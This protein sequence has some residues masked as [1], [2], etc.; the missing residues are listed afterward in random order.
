VRIRLVVVLATL[1]ALTAPAR[2]FDTLKY[3]GN[4]TTWPSWP[5]KY[6]LD[7]AGSSDVA[8]AQ[9]Q[10]AIQAA[11]Q[12][13][14]DVDCCQL[15]FSYGGTKGYSNSWTGVWVHFTKSNWDPSVGDA[16][17]YSLSWKDWNGNITQSEINF[18]DENLSWTTTGATDFF[19][20]FSDIQGVATHEIGHTLG[21]DHSKIREA[22]MFFSGGSQEL[23]TLKQDDRNGACFLYPTSSFTQGQV[24]DACS[25]SANCAAGECVQYAQGGYNY[26]GK[27]CSSDSQCPDGYFCYT[28]DGLNTCIADT[29]Y[30]NQGGNNVGTG[31]YCWGMEV[32]QSSVCL[33][34]P[35]TAYC[36]QECN[37]SSSSGC[38][39]GYT[40][41][42]S[43]TQGYCIKQ[44]ATAIGGT[45]SMDLEC[46]SGRCVVLCVGKSYCSQECGAGKPACPGGSTCSQGFCM[47]T[48]SLALGAACSCSVDCQSGYC[49][50]AEGAKKCLKPCTSDAEC[51]GSFCDGGVCA[52]G[53][54]CK[55]DASCGAGKFC[56]FD[57]PTQ[58]AGTCEVACNPMFDSGCPA[59]QVCQW[60]YMGWLDALRGRCVAANGGGGKGA[61]CDPSSAP[62]ENH[63]ICAN[64]GQG[65]QCYVDCR[66]DDGAG[67]NG[68]EQCVG[69]GIGMDP[70]HGLCV[71][72]PPGVEPHEVVQPPEVTPQ[73]DTA[74][75]PEG[76]GPTVVGKGQPCMPPATVC[77]AGLTCAEAG[78]GLRCYTDCNTVTGGCAADEQC[79]GWNDPANR[80]VC[81]PRPPQSEGQGEVSQPIEVYVPPQETSGGEDPG[82]DRGGA[83]GGFGCSTGGAGGPRGG[84]LSLL[85]LALLA[86]GARRRPA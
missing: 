83:G 77:T 21:L 10:S 79:V 71:P 60:V 8:F 44:G 47:V 38:P 68:D 36:S 54:G 45:C 63:L 61:G 85:A 35:G 76:S 56:R 37:P 41:M 32:C 1:C 22:V 24:C 50:G 23:R 64:A 39:A 78:Q 6:Y 86:L 65:Q 34:L 15:T 73:Q 28:Q 14:Q 17:A 29:Y 70:K 13:W 67:C 25:S 52:S 53:G 55:D 74:W 20:P 31:G 40:C 81:L 62:C 59:G 16:A 3:N 48:G 7:P 27:D 80:G 75:Q 57:S 5:V 9:V 4:Q 33:A 72:L 58:S 69:M 46:Q 12:T 42:G 11:F 51:P 30:C 43:G 26:C 82:L 19:S 66:T 2:A 84:W 49:G 18:N